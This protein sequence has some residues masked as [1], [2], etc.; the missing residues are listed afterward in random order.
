MGDTGSTAL[1][2]LAAGFSLWGAQERVFPFWMAL[3]IFSPF[4]ADATVTLI[5]RVLRRERVWLAHRDH[6]YQRL[7]LSGWEPPESLA[8]GIHRDVRCGHQRGGR[9]CHAGA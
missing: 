8:G 2:L 3:L 5:R 7:I 1:G 9:P 4:I 6:Y